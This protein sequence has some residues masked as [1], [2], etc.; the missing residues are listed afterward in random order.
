[1]A[2]HVSIYVRVWCIEAKI[3]KLTELDRLQHCNAHLLKT[4]DIGMY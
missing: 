1:M 3:K 2:D 4:S